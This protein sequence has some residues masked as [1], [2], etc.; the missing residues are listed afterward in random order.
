MLARAKRTID[1]FTSRI[2]EHPVMMPLMVAAAMTAARAPRQ[3]V[4][5]AST[6]A[7]D[8]ERLIREVHGA[9]RPGTGL[10]LVPTDGADPWL[11]ERVPTL[12]GMGMVDAEAVAYICENF[13]CQRPVREVGENQGVQR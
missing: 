4:I 9:Y 1:L 6:D 12:A 13:V 2:A 3:I 10:V 8:T 11:L 5:A 7:A